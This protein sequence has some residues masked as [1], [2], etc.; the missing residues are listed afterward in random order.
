VSHHSLFDSLFDKGGLRAKV[1]TP[2]GC[3]LSAVIQCPPFSCVTNGMP[4]KTRARAAA[5]QKR[6]SDGLR[7]RE[8][9][10][11]MISAGGKKAKTQA[12]LH[13][14]VTNLY[15]VILNHY[16]AVYTRFGKV[17]PDVVAELVSKSIPLNKFNHC[18]VIALAGH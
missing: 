16:N 7:T 5:K 13:T 10:D 11:A 8:D 9:R 4:P 14:A 6:T 12:K 18:P 1:A 15:V 2:S 3:L 17:L